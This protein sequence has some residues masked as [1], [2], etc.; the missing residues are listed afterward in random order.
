MANGGTLK[1]GFYGIMTYYINSSEWR[2]AQQ[3]QRNTH[4]CCSIYTQK[5]HHCYRHQTVDGGHT[6]RNYCIAF[7]GTM[8]SKCIEDK[9]A[10]QKYLSTDR[11]LEI[12]LQGQAHFYAK[13]S[14]MK[15]I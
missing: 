5:N 14:Q 12:R 9:D 4:S 2:T 11:K 1:E 3:A 7:I 15:N 13:I 6:L 10:I 8:E